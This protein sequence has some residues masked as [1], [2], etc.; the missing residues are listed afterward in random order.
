MTDEVITDSRTG[1]KLG[2]MEF[3]VGEAEIIDKNSK[4]SIAKIDSN[5]DLSEDF[6]PVKYYVK[7]QKKKKKDKAKSKIKEKKKKISEEW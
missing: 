4:F 2:K 7:P 6:K 3:K 5:D 1:E